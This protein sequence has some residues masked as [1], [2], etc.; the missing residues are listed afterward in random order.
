MPEV[1]VPL[2]ALS[3]WMMTVCATPFEPR[4]TLGSLSV[5]AC[6]QLNL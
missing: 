3:D 5:I 6:A 1:A 2:G 4:I